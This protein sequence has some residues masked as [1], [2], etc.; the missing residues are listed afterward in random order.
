MADIFDQLNNN[1]KTTSPDVVL[2]L[3]L[4]NISVYAEKVKSSIT[5]NVEE[6]KKEVKEH[7]SYISLFFKNFADINFDKVAQTAQKTK[8]S[9]ENQTIAL[10]DI[11]VQIEKMIEDNQEHEK[12]FKTYT[13]KT[14]KFLHSVYDNG[15]RVYDF[16]NTDVVETYK[17]VKDYISNT[18]QTILNVGK[19]LVESKTGSLLVDRFDDL[20]ENTVD[21]LFNFFRNKG[22]I[23]NLFFGTLQG[24][25]TVFKWVAKT[26]IYA[27]GWI[28]DKFVSLAKIGWKAVGAVFSVIGSAITTVA[29]IFI[30]SLTSFLSNPWI[31]L[32]IGILVY[33]FL[34]EIKMFLGKVFTGVWD[35]IKT[36]WGKLLSN[37]FVSGILEMTS[38]IWSTIS[39]SFDGFLKF[40]GADEIFKRFFATTKEEMNVLWT[41]GVSY[42]SDAWKIVKSYFGK[43]SDSGV[44]DETIIMWNIISDIVNGPQKTQEEVDTKSLELLQKVA[45]DQAYESVKGVVL[46]AFKIQFGFI[47]DQETEGNL[48]TIANNSFESFKKTL[49]ESTDQTLKNIS[50]SLN[51]EIG[52]LVKD[53]LSISPLNTNNVL[54][55]IDNNKSENFID[56]VLKT[57]NIGRTSGDMNKY[58][59]EVEK[60][61]E[62]FSQYTKKMVDFNNM[63]NKSS[64]A[65]SSFYSD[66]AQKIIKLNNDNI[67]ANDKYLVTVMEGKNNLVKF[68]F[69]SKYK[70]TFDKINK[71]M[72]NSS[73]NDA[74]VTDDANKLLKSIGVKQD[75]T[76]TQIKDYFKYNL[77]KDTPETSSTS[78]NISPK[79][80]VPAMSTGGIV[81]QPMTALI[82]EAGY[83][84]MV[85]PLNDDGIKFIKDTIINIADDKKV[86][87]SAPTRN[88]SIKSIVKRLNSGSQPEADETMFDLKNLSTG[89]IGIY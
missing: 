43:L 80:T 38:N 35:Y 19:K 34:P 1:G 2:K 63:I 27:I 48:L 33:S 71:L 57:I 18:Y 22:I 85:I 86:T 41:K 72:L 49:S 4:N 12:L 15:Q 25:A 67:I 58:D 70:T 31:L 50:S 5:E 17:S 82:G 23:L 51:I 45:T 13:S 30:D 36:S 81:S 26:A 69:L 56:K 16:L 68:D 73:L 66:V 88:S 52:T 79:I 60:V 74:Q 20:W 10:K 83:P 55:R 59:A 6:H 76:L 61:G 37:P 46:N 28:Y 44:F 11:D 7:I 9:I 40:V 3:T 39:S 29:E 14:I 75:L 42:M 62:S 78:V 54:Q 84:E 8:I 64:E 24:I 77:L 87:S 32:G 47:N 21:K 89:I 65:S 53:V